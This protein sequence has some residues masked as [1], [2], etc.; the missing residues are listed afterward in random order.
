MA[1]PLLKGLGAGEEL[2]KIM[3]SRKVR[4]GV[5]KLRNRK[6]SQRKGPLVVYDEDSGLVRAFR[7]ISGVETACVDRLNL[8][9]VAPGASFGLFVIWTE[10]AFN[11]LNEIYGT[12]K[13]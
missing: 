11:K 3:T 4:G 2:D 6:Y 9:K 13:S 12:A 7:N 10:S 1:S 8:L 5:S